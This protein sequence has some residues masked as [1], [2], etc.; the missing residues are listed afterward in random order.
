MKKTLTIAVLCLICGCSDKEIL[1]NADA[2]DKK[3]G[4][5]GTIACSVDA[6]NYLRSIAVHD[7]AWDKDTEGLLGVKFDRILSNVVQPGVITYI[8][9]KA[10]LQNGFGAFTHIE[11]YCNYDTQNDKVLGFTNK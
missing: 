11:L 3:Y 6:D 5:K 1:N 9:G 10:K 4:T 2:L 8:S 7:F